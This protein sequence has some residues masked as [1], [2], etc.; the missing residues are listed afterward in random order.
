MD[1]LIDLSER[2]VVTLH[3]SANVPPE[4]DCVHRVIAEPTLFF[5]FD[6]HVF[7]WKTEDDALALATTLLNQGENAHVA[8][9][10]EALGWTTRRINPPIGWLIHQELAIGSEAYDPEFE[11][12]CL[13]A[14]G[15]TKR[16]VR[17]GGRS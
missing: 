10:R 9:L 11:S 4:F 1:G 6:R 12:Y 7:G 8:P 3:H 5:E 14:N 13:L 15:Q 17:R 2:G 16:F